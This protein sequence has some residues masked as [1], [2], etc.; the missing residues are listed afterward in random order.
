MIT[1]LFRNA[2]VFTPQDAGK[3]KGGADQ[4]RIR[5]LERGALLCRNGRLEAVGVEEEVLKSLSFKDVDLEVDLKGRCVIPGFVDPHTHLC[6]AE[7]REREFSLRLQGVEYLEILRRGGG[8]LST[9]RSVR[10]TDEKALFRATRDRAWAAVRFGTTTMEIKSG[11]GLETAT[12]LKML[13]VIRRIGRE[14]PLDVVPTFM[15]AHAV[16][17]EYRHRSDDYVDLILHEMLPAVVRQGIARFCDVF[18]EKGVFSI[19]QSRRILAAA[20]QAG[21]GVKI[22]ADEVHD[23]GGARLAA[24][25][26]AV[27]AEHLLASSEESLRAMAASGT[28]AVLLP[29]TA[30]SLRKPFAPGRTMIDLGVPVALATDANPG[31]SY[32]ESM[33]FV[34]G[35]AVLMMGLSVEEA[36]SAATLNAAY[37]VGMADRVGSLDVGKQADFLVLEAETPAGIAYHAGANP[38]IAV[39]KKGERVFGHAP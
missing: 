27:S 32:T 37:A 18:C 25:M 39:Y 6:F 35:L 38:V 19:D 5:V 15:G 17:E 21:L 33:P 20:R 3:P 23:L 4:G 36:L 11:Y 30:Y 16:P 8:I 12:E 7:T 2:A 26:G 14:T 31:S 22:H 1:K 29:A 28:I 13:R 24:E 34:F 9:V 10:T